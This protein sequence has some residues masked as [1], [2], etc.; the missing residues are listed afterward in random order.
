MKM[1]RTQF[2]IWTLTRAAET[3]RGLSLSERGY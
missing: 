1:G 2:G 3:Q